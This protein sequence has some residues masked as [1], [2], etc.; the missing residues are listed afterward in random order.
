MIL[1]TEVASSGCLKTS[2]TQLIK[3]QWNLTL[4]TSSSSS[5]KHFMKRSKTWAN[6][7]CSALMP[8]L[9]KDHGPSKWRR[10]ISIPKA[11]TSWPIWSTCESM[12]NEKESRNIRISQRD[13]LTNTAK[14]WTELMKRIKKSPKN[15]TKDKSGTIQVQTLRLRWRK[16]S[17]KPKTK[18]F[19]SILLVSTFLYLLFYNII[20]IIDFMR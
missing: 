12:L 8:S 6:L 15:K 11:T 2:L 20:L 17:K 1:R 7:L 10:N 4:S 3:A 9:M 19:L 5:A 16:H 14:S 18:I 13:Q